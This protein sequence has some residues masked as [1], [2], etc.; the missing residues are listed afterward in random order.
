MVLSCETAA[1]SFPSRLKSTH[2][3]R[4]DGL[5]ASSFRAGVAVAR[6]Q[7]VMARSFEAAD[8]SVRPSGLKVTL[9]YGRASRAAGV[10]SARSVCRGYPV[11]A[12]HRQIELS[13]DAEAIVLPSG[14]KLTLVTTSPGRSKRC[15]DWPLLRSQRW[16]RL[17]SDPQAS[18]LPSGLK[19]ML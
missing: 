4:P 7:I 10:G 3:A 15:I 19:R 13:R 14:E 1:S 6:S 11:P 2:D 8:A 12:S 16:M 9:T 18:I 5:L 17:S